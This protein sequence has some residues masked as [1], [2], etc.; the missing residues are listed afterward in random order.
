MSKGVLTNIEQRGRVGQDMG[1]NQ[2][3][4]DTHSLFS[5]EGGTGEN[6]EVQ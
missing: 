2:G 5:G 4:T 1:R 6:T 3:A